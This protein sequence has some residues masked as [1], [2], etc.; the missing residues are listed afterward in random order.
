MVGEKLGFTSSAEYSTYFAVIYVFL[1]FLIVQVWNMTFNN[2]G[3][4]FKV[5]S[6]EDGSFLLWF[7]IFISQFFLWST[8][9]TSQQ[10]QTDQ[11]QQ[12]QQ[13]LLQQQQADQLQQQQQQLLLNL[14][15]K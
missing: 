5:N 2:Y 3:C 7:S 12:Q 10:Q 4:Y 9:L 15:A 11:L 1:D 8:I 14:D 6:M 13:Q